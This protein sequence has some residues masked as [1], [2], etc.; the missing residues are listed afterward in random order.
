MK[1][2]LTEVSPIKRRIEVTVDSE[3]VEQAYAKAFK[4]ALKMLAIPGFRR[5]K[6]PAYIGRKHIANSMLNRE[7]IENL[8]PASLREAVEQEKIDIVSQPDISKISVQRG[9]ELTYT[10]EFEVIPVIELKDYEGIPIEQER[11]EPT[12]KDV[13]EAIERARN[14]RAVLEDVND[15]GLQAED[16]AIVDY[17]SFENGKA[18]KNGNAKDFPMELRPAGYVPGFL[19][20]LYG[21]KAG[22]EKEFDVE[23]PADYK[24]ELAGRT[25]HFHFS[26][27]SVKERRLPELDE[28]FVKAVS[29]VNTVEELKARIMESMKQQSQNEAEQHIAEKIYFKIASQVPTD[30]IPKA[31]CQYH[32]AVFN[33]RVV[34]NLRAQN[35]RLADMLKE[36]NRTE[37]DWIKH[38]NL[39]GYGEARLEILVKNLARQLNISVSDEDVNKLIDEE[40]RRTRQTAASIRKQME[41]GGVIKQLQYSLLRDEITQHLVNSAAV[42]YIKPKTAEERAAEAAKLAEEAAKAA[43]EVKAEE[44]KA[45]ENKA[46]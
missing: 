36:Q 1:V 14:G 12:E 42:T 41:R 26:V 11:Y 13:D 19:E 44:N 24:S 7:V 20:N 5:G 25:I 6:V 43:E 34:G 23:F 4:D 18:V 40:A 32:A 37:E 16:I 10:A 31:L 29:D 22:E 39:M 30:M 17:E 3:T 28:N 15:R 38:V 21:L 35:K 8:V 27:K 33:E 2:S 45:E 9:K 46:E